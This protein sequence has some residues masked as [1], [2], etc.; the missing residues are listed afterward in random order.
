MIHINLKNVFAGILFSIFASNGNAQQTL[1]LKDALSYALENNTLMEQ[2]KIDI[3]NSYYT[4]AE[5]R[6]SAL[7]QINAN[8]SLT[9]NVIVTSF[10]L[11]ASFMGGPADEFIAIRAGQTWGSVIQ[12]TLSQQI[13]NQQLFAGLKA[14]KGSIDLFKIAAEVAEENVLQQVA[15]AYYQVVITKQNT[16]VLDANI[17]RVKDLEKILESQVEIGLVKKV[18]LDR[19]KVNR[20][21]LEAQRLQLNNGIVQVENLLKYY[22]GM[23][24]NESITISPDAFSD[25][26]K[27][28]GS[29]TNENEQFDPEQLVSYKVLQKQEELLNLQIKVNKAEYVPYLY[30]SGYYNYNTSS[31][32][33]NLYTKKALSYD[34][35]AFALNLA[36]PIFDGLAKNA[37]IKKSQA[38]LDHFRS[39]MKNTSNA[40]N[41]NYHNA[42]SQ[43]QN[44]LQTITAQELNKTLAKEVY[45]MTN[46]NYTNGLASLTDLINAEA[47]LITAEHSYNEALLKLKV[48]QVELLK[49]NGKIGTLLN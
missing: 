49:S 14:A 24:I 12:V 29:I 33:F 16:V 11:P 9:N 7:P 31:N 32:N 5:A 28:A 26:E 25:L 8:V 15:A 4:V 47:E 2:A 13:Y 40:L 19:V 10:V 3:Q 20:A 18:D 22:M 37:R 38:S 39:E 34:M 36:I 27:F 35:S 44:S 42:T 21:N 23:P 46:A 41:M 45:D 48:A 1:S 6:A 17:K 30:L 43:I